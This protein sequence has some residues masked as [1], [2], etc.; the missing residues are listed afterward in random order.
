MQLAQGL[1]ERVF[2][3]MTLADE[4]NL[5]AAYVAGVE[6]YRRDAGSAGKPASK[7]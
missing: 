7:A 3:W 5:L 4:R 1:H 2:A 6:Q